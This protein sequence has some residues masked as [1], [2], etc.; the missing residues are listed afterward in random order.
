[1]GSRSVGDHPAPVEEVRRQG[2]PV[3]LFAADHRLQ[4][5]AHSETSILTLSDGTPIPGNMGITASDVETRIETLFKPYHR[6]ISS[7]LDDIRQEA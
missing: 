6:A 3:Q 2:N 5:A 1:M 4:S 7:A